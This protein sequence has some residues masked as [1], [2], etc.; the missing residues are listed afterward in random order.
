[1]IGSQR[2]DVWWKI[3]AWELNSPR[4]IAAPSARADT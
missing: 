4:L 3:F 1:V 2:F